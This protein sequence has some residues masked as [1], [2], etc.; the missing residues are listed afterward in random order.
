M[1][2]FM[3]HQTHSVVAPLQKFNPKRTT[4]C[5]TWQQRGWWCRKK[6]QCLF[7]MHH[8]KTHTQPVKKVS[9]LVTTQH[10]GRDGRVNR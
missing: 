8:Q 3:H 5:G 7:F 4:P 10:L 9:L 6:R 2:F 1:Y